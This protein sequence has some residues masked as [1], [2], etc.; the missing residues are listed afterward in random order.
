[1]ISD[2]EPISKLLNDDPDLL[3]AVRSCLGENFKDTV[4]LDNVQTQIRNMQGDP[5]A[6][7]NLT[8]LAHSLRLVGTAKRV[9]ETAK[10]VDRLCEKWGYIHDS[11]EDDL[12]MS[13]CEKLNG[14]RI[15]SL[16]LLVDG[17]ENDFVDFDG[18]IYG[19]TEN[20]VEVLVLVVSMHCVRDIHFD[21]QQ[22]MT[23][24]ERDECLPT[25]V[26]RFKDAYD[27]LLE[28]WLKKQVTDSKAFRK[29]EMQSSI[30]ALL[31][32]KNVK[33]VAAIGGRD[34]AEDLQ[35][36]C[37]VKKYWSLVHNGEAYEINVIM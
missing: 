24:E 4:T 11:L 21:L 7:T 12:M 33:I 35:K 19:E 14:V 20:G 17:D 36:S 25:R 29:F 23:D 30:V 28:L 34:F 5:S 15:D 6:P 1:M 31:K 32:R 9:E 8:A 37:K 3:E 22:C 13:L 18:V 10:N 26:E 2:E 27:G 16:E